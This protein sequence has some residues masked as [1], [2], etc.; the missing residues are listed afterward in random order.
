MIPRFFTYETPRSTPGPCGRRRPAPP[1]RLRGQRS[2]D[3]LPDP[4]PV[5]AAGPH[6]LRC[7]GWGRHGHPRPGHR[8]G[9]G[10]GRGPRPAL[11][12]RG[13]FCAVQCRP[14]Q[15]PAAP[16]PGRARD[17]WSRPGVDRRARRAGFSPGRGAGHP[18]HPWSGCPRRLLRPLPAA[19]GPVGDR[20]D[21]GAHGRVLGGLDL[22]DRHHR[23]VA[24]RSDLH[25]PDRDVHPG[26]YRPA[27]EAAQPS[28]WSL[29]RR[30]GGAADA[31]VVPAGQ[32]AGG[33]HPQGRG[34]TPQRDH[35][36]AAGRFLV[37]V[38]PGA[39]VDACGGAG[40]GGGGAAAPGWPHGLSDGV[41]RTDPGARGLSAV[42]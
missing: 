21:G 39:A 32:G 9:G 20:A 24:A 23:D 18:G 4:A 26:T 25:G 28:W 10:R 16:P 42:A 5:L 15:V 30:G 40:G 36:D 2:A 8:R 19:A 34:R 31:G 7:L 17:R 35:G 37:G 13:D 41:A 11:V 27:V 6:H 33:H 1:G 12:R 22:R 14:H 38:R 29:P 3:H